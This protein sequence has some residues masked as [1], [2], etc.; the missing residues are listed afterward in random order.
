MQIKRNINKKSISFQQKVN[1]T[2]MQRQVDDLASW[3]EFNETAYPDSVNKKLK[4]SPLIAYSY[5]FYTKVCILL[6]TIINS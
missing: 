6:Q 5:F 2:E 1:Q 4:W 3:H